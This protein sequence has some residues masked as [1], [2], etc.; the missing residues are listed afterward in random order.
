M[1]PSENTADG[2]ANGS[3][4]STSASRPECSGLGNTCRSVMSAAGSAM[5]RGPEM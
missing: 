2:G 4:F 3:V 1:S 5:V